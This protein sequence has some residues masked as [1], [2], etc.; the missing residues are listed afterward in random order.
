MTSSRHSD[1]SRSLHADD[2]WLRDLARRLLRDAS[3]AEDAAQQTWLSVLRS[4]PRLGMSRGFLATALGRVAVKIQSG[5]QRRHERER[6]AAAPE[7]LG[8]QSVVEQLELRRVILAAVL[9]LEPAYRDVILLR[10]YED[11]GVAEIAAQQGVPLATVKTRLARAE[12]RLAARLDA[13]GGGDR[14]RWLPALV[15][16]AQ[17]GAAEIAGMLLTLFGGGLAMAVKSNVVVSLALG[18]AVVAGV[19]LF[20]RDAPPPSEPP[21]SVAPPAPAAAAQPP[22]LPDREAAGA[23]PA[24]APARSVAEAAT[25][26]AEAPATA[27]GKDLRRIDGFAFDP[28]GSPAEAL[29]AFRAEVP[30]GK[31][32]P[33]PI[34][35]RSDAAGRFAVEVPPS[36]AGA[37]EAAGPRTATV[38][39]GKVGAA[40]QPIAPV[41]VVAAGVLLAGEVLD[42]EGRPVASAEVGVA[43]M[44]GVRRRIPAPLEYSQVVDFRTSS[45]AAGRFAFSGLVPSFAAAHLYVTAAGFLSK[46]Q[47]VPESDDLALRLVVE[48][49]SPSAEDRVRGQVIDTFGAPVANAEVVLGMAS[50]RSDERGLF[51]LDAKHAEDADVI[52]A[53]ALGAQGAELSWPLD[54]PAEFVVLRLGPP[55]LEIRGVVRTADGAPARVLVQPGDGEVLGFTAPPLGLLKL[56]EEQAGGFL[57]GVDTDAEGAFVLPGLSP[58]AYRL[59]V[60]DGKSGAAHR[61]QPIAAGSRDIVIDLPADLTFAEVAGRVVDRAGEPVAG[62]AVSISATRSAAIYLGGSYGSTSGDIG[63]VMTDAGGRFVLKDVPRAEASIQVSGDDIVDKAVVVPAAPDDDFEIAVDRRRYL[64]VELAEGDPATRFKIVDADGDPMQ[65]T[66]TEATSVY[67]SMVFDLT[68]GRSGVVSVPTTAKAVV[69]YSGDKEVRRVPLVFEETGVAT[70]R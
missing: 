16:I 17:P 45:D 9:E 3:L 52:R 27:S 36:T 6:A 32:G 70:V 64:R 26:T 15:A 28:S 54:P 53:V 59:R 22:E 43:L 60:Y 18:L 34:E 4:P 40:H 10:F 55:A 8:L 35:T 29:L 20:D 7:K 1:L 49:P 11:L 50:A 68:E 39:R 63:R 19:V 25:A 66:L 2:R 14:Q 31:A 44:D 21:R 33:E 67:I 5:E 51:D 61:T 24:S 41:V 47:A 65:M 58:R 48:R 38:Y 46:S 69:L 42:A 30:R 62:A 37:I 57:H 12:E 23:A 13:L 56:V